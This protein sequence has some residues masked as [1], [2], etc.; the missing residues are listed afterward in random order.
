MIWSCTAKR[1]ER[2]DDPSDFNAGIEAETPGDAAREIAKVARDHH[3]FSPA[4][5]EIFIDGANILYF[6][7]EPWPARWVM[8]VDLPFFRCDYYPN[9][10][11]PDFVLQAGFYAKSPEHA[12]EQCAAL[13]REEQG[14]DLDWLV[15]GGDEYRLRDGA[16]VKP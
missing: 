6:E 11:N 5:V 1:R 8:R 15:V 3:D 9:D 12:A 7:A 16:W 13:A 4:V 10:L 14:A 2:G